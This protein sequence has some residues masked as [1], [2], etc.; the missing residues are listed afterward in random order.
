MFVATLEAPEN[1]SDDDEDEGE[2]AAALHPGERGPI[3]SWHPFATR[4]RSVPYDPD[5]I[6]KIGE[7]EFELDHADAEG[8]LYTLSASKVI[9]GVF[10]VGNQRYIVYYDLKTQEVEKKTQPP[11]AA[12]EP[13]TKAGK[14]EVFIVSSHLESKA[15]KGYRAYV[16]NDFSQQE[17]PHKPG[18]LF[19]DTTEAWDGGRL[20]RDHY[21]KQRDKIKVTLSLPPDTTDA[22][23]D[24][25]Y[26]VRWQVYDPDDPC[27]SK[28][29]D[30]N[31]AV[32][33]DNTGNPHE[34]AGHWFMPAGHEI[35]WR[36]QLDVDEQ[37]N[38]KKKYVLLEQAE[39]KISSVNNQYVSTV[40]FYFSDDGG[41]NYLIK[42]LLTVPTRK[43]RQAVC[44]DRSGEL[45]VWRKRWVTVYAM[46]RSESR[47]RCVDVF[48][49]EVVG[50]R[51]A[52]S[53]PHR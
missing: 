24:R 51:C 27:Q 20:D 34:G 37:K 12:M 4:V 14:K 46:A 29:I 43:G 26:R 5:L 53:V 6:V 11:D 31:G 33:G 28:D 7:A 36:G 22:Q 13:E 42:V 25:V 9:A 41:D 47:M 30:K 17:D 15:I 49:C 23:L 21:D 32:G 2:W 38:N 19:I 50:R 1:K 3:G 16:L 44:S 48:V 8:Y 52:G 10:Q 40:H 39:T 35:V 18:R 45:V